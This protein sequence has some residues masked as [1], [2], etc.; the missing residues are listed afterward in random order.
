M[1]ARRV[2]AA[3][4]RLRATSVAS[5]SA[6]FRFTLVT[7]ARTVSP[8]QPAAHEDD[9]AVQAGD[10]VAAVR[11]RLDLELELLVLLDGGGHGASLAGC[12]CFHLGSHGDAAA[13][14]TRC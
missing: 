7:R 11:E 13:G 10:A 8:G 3:R 5:A 12:A 9:E 2:D 1:L 14:T 4:A 6:W